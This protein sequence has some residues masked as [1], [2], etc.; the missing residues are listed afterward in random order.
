MKLPKF[1]KYLLALLLVAAVG[2]CTISI[3]YELQAKQIRSSY[4]TTLF[5]YYEAQDL[6]KKY[7][8]V[9][10]IN[11]EES[12]KTA[13]LELKNCLV[14]SLSTPLFG[15]GEYRGEPGNPVS[16][17]IS[18]IAGEF[19]SGNTYTFK[20]TGDYV[21]LGQSWQRTVLVTVE[22]KFI[23]DVRGI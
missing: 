22:G 4:D 13:Q 16:Y 10:A 20:I 23:V 15:L 2:V 9:F 6:A 18:Y 14:S 1:V 17:S 21:S 11:D 19:N 8:S 7:M 3:I 12:Y 5:D